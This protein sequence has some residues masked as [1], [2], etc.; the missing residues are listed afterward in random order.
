M[1]RIEKEAPKAYSL[2]ITE[3]ALQDIDNI[4]FYIAYFRHQI[5]EFIDFSIRGESFILSP[6]VRIIAFR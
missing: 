4:T 3:H 2:R 1:D 5:H 6:V